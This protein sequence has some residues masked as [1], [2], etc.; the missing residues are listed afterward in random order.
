MKN[1]LLFFGAIVIALFNLTGCGQD[2]PSTT[3]TETVAP[4]E[5]TGQNNQKTQITQPS[6]T[7]TETPEPE[8]E[9]NDSAFYDDNPG[10]RTRR[11]KFDRG[12]TSK[13][14]K[15]AVIRGTRD[16]YLFGANK[17]Q[18]MNV[19]I[20]SLEDNAVF[21]VVSPDG[22]ILER[23]T[24]NWSGEL[25]QKGDYKIVVGGTAGNATYELNTE[26]K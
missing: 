20:T 14:V 21:D 10:N 24:K 4:V 5:T 18:Q 26:I 11:V 19:D 1:Q 3:N 7:T 22:Q 17:G 15:D 9:P 2:S 13:T 6:S 16:I 8:S 12:A 23:E 25:P